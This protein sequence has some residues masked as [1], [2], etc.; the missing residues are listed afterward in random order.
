M[1]SLPVPI[2][3]NIDN[4]KNRMKPKARPFLIILEFF[5]YCLPPKL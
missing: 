1:T 4:R 3:A 5:I 2:G